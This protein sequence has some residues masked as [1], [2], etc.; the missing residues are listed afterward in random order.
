MGSLDQVL[1]MIPG[2]AP[3]VL[4][5]TDVDER[6][7]KRLDAIINSMT[8]QERRK[9]DVIN[10]KRRKRIA[11]G[12]GTTVQDVN[13]LLRQFSQMRRMMKSMAKGGKRGMMQQLQQKF[14]G[15]GGTPFPT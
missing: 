5:N 1:S 12:S 15:R 14:G 10:G 3:D 6:R 2:V 8:L 9:P 7:L 13:Q 11:R 4:N